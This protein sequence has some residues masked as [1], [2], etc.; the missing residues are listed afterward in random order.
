MSRYT[1]CLCAFAAVMAAALCPTAP[2]AEPNAD[3]AAVRAIVDQW[4]RAH[5]LGLQGADLIAK[6]M[7]DS[8]VAIF[9]GTKPT[10]TVVNKAAFVKKYAEM[11]RTRPHKSRVHKVER[12]VVT[13]TLAVEIGTVVAVTAD[14][15]QRSARPL[16]VFA[17]EKSGWRLVANIPA[18]AVVALFQPAR[19]G[20]VAKSD[21]AALKAARAA[22]DEF[23]ARSN[24]AMAA[25]K[26]TGKLE[27]DDLC[28]AG[29]V[30]VVPSW[31]TATVLDKAGMQKI[32]NT[33]L[34]QRPP[35]RCRE[36][37]RRVVVVSDTVALALS[38]FD[39]VPPG[40]TCQRQLFVH[41]L[42][43]Q[44][45]G[46][47]RVFFAPAD[48]LRR[49]L[50]EPDEAAA[51]RKAADEFVGLFRTPNGTPLS[52]LGAI[53]HETCVQV[54]S[55][56][57]IYRGRAANVD[58]FTRGVT[59]IRNGFDTFNASYEMDDIRVRGD[60]AMV[61]GRIQ[62]MGR[63][64]NGQDFRRTVLETLVF[65]NVDGAWRLTH[66][67]SSLPQLPKPRKDR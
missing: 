29:F 63:T 26:G 24:R 8:S 9:L 10:A 27:A 14:G 43:R 39:Q 15:R 12:V 49:G 18:E 31:P 3:E 45:D 57:Q 21:P 11:L 30:G 52:R 60:A 33:W 19:G 20:D 54:G 36:T 40:G 32:R 4:N 51:V 23:A 41:G 59:E 2:A 13:G 46:W 6:T 56:G 61:F 44:A 5:R 7:S 38:Q 50:G 34:A 42:A 17:K 62:M 35:G 53:L 67:H 58:L 47:K 66:E 22:V 25:P 55:N 37:V 64:K 28:D 16:S 1:W 48:P 65:R